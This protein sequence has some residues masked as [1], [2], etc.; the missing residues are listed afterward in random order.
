MLKMVIKEVAIP[1]QGSLL[2]T[3]LEVLAE[4]S[5]DERAWRQLYK[6]VRPF[7]FS[8]NFRFLHGAHLL[9]E[10]ATQE[11]FLR[12]IR[13]GDFTRFP[14][15]RSLKAYLKVMCRNV[16]NDLTRRLSQRAEV[17]AA[18]VD[19]RSMR[20]PAG[21]SAKLFLRDLESTLGTDDKRLF[22]LLLE[23]WTTAEISGFLSISYGAAA[24]RIHRLKV[25]LR[26]QLEEKEQVP[27]R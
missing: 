8:M 3:A 24:V 1:D 14:N 15:E 7:V 9:A 22:T 12:L 5:T 6:C 18:E 25:N 21:P 10:D 26:R 13:Y 16:V 17:A 19:V 20:G 2:S 4:A 27:V 11:V 23:G